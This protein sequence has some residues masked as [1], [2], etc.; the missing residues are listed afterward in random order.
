VGL[1]PGIG[2]LH[3]DTPN[4]DSLACDIMEVCRVKVDAFVL[5]WLQSEP[6]R[7]SDFWED[8]NGNCRLLSALASRL[9][10]TADT[11]CKLV[12]PVA[13]YVAQ[14]LWSSIPKGPKSQ[15]GRATPL[16]QRHRTEGRGNVFIPN[17][18]PVL[19]L[20]KI[21]RSC[22]VSLKAGR[23]HCAD[24]SRSMSRPI[25]FEGRRLGQIATHRPDAEALR[26]ET[27][28]QQIAA[29]KAWEES[30]EPERISEEIYSHNIQ[31]RLAGFTNSAIASALRVSR[32]YAAGIRKGRRRPHPRHWQT[33]ARLVGSQE[34][35][36]SPASN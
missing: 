17:S 1:D 23:E 18:K 7:K 21:C 10:E 9:S 19:G 32:P 28:R 25:L 13:E 34:L 33:L 36:R 6:L 3:V 16:T 26:A 35:Q 8:R 27:Q 12:A 29:R 31:P 2:L 20:E 22:G 5:H 4:R 11:W 24:C 30:A 15:R 14:E